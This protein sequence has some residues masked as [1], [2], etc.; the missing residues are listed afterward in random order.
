MG[1]I[2]I[3][4]KGVSENLLGCSTSNMHVYGPGLWDDGAIRGGG[5]KIVYASNGEQRKCSA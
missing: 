5:K 3:L 1:G 2:N 4:E